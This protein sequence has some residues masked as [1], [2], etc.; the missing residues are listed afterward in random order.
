LYGSPCG[1]HSVEASSTQY[2]EPRL[3][4]T[5]AW[6]RRISGLER[7]QAAFVTTSRYTKPAR[8]EAEKEDFKRIGL[9]DG[10]QL[11]DIFNEQYERLSVE[12]RER[13]RL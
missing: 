9:I 6:T 8:K 11:V 2:P 5:P 10:E 12:M 4:R 1:E 7:A 3:A 13:L